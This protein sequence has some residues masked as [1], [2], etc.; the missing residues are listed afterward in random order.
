[1]KNIITT[2]QKVFFYPF[3]NN[4]PNFFLT[5]FVSFILLFDV[6]LRFDFGGLI[7]FNL[8]QVLYNYLHFTLHFVKCTHFLL[9]FALICTYK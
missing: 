1:M 4:F 8:D 6:G 9:K 7:C 3:V 5:V 2:A